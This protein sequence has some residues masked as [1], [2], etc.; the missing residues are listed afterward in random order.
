[1][2]RLWR[3][4]GRAGAA[5]LP[6]DLAPW[7]RGTDGVVVMPKAGPTAPGRGPGDWELSEGAG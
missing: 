2:R 4:G 3:G 7:H 5:L 1:M 6:A